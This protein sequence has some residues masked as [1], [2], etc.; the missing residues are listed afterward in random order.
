MGYGASVLQRVIHKGK[1][2]KSKAIGLKA[3]DFYSKLPSDQ[4]RQWAIVLHQDENNHYTQPEASKEIE[5]RITKN[6]PIPAVDGHEDPQMRLLIEKHQTGHS[7]KQDRQVEGMH[8][9][10]EKGTQVEKDQMVAF[11]NGP[12]N[13]KGF[14]ESVRQ[15]ELNETL[16]T[17]DTKDAALRSL[18]AVP[19]IQPSALVDS[20]GKTTFW[21]DYQRETS[22]PTKYFTFPKTTKDADGNAMQDTHINGSTYR[23]D[24]D[25]EKHLT[26]GSTSDKYHF[27]VD[28]SL[29]TNFRK[30]TR[31][32]SLA[33]RNAK[34]HKK[35][36][37]SRTDIL[38]VK[39]SARAEQL[40]ETTNGTVLYLNDP[41]DLEVYAEH[42]QIHT[43]KVNTALHRQARGF[44]VDGN[45]SESDV[46]DYENEVEMDVDTDDEADKRIKKRKL[47]NKK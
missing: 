15:G 47:N 3:S 25:G 16:L 22:Y 43:D 11:L 41:D 13:A 6:L 42:V 2:H 18:N 33:R 12:A 40:Y 28:E 10:Y 26:V 7:R 38:K 31:I 23:E 14:T 17:S 9:L 21:T 37:A 4:H 24:S 5:D 19:G 30:S 34:F 20:T 27:G 35:S 45:E 44:R 32:P 29:S 8:G 36:L 39:A 1:T 46:S